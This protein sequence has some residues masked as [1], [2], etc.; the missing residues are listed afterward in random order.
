MLQNRFRI[1]KGE[2]VLDAGCGASPF[3]YA[4]HL[5]DVSLTD[6]SARFDRPVPPTHLPFYECSV[7][8][9]PFADKEFDFVYCSHV[10]E[11]VADPAAACREIMRVGR[12]GYIECPRSWTEYAFHAMDHRWLVDHERNCLIFRE[13]LDEEKRD[14]LGIQYSIFEWLRDHR[15]RAHWDSPQMR[16]IRCVEFYWEGEFN[17]LVIPRSQRNNAGAHGS[18]YPARRTRTRG[19]DLTAQ[20]ELLHS[21]FRRVLG[22]GR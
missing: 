10:L 22:R 16:A 17:F 21:E 18:F 8:S 14:H 20:R 4:T 1:R 6:N 5:A 11:H 19:R 15:F 7:M 9:M 12:R 3:L 2:K 13:K